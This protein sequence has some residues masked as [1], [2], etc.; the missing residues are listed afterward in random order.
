MYRR[1]LLAMLLAALAGCTTK[2]TL[3]VTAERS[4]SAD[5]PGYRT[6]R[7]RTPPVEPIPGQPRTGR[8]L[9]DWR[10][11]NVV[12]NQL[13]AKGYR[14]DSSRQADLVVECHV[15][16]KEKHTD[17]INDFIQ[18]RESGGQEGP[19]ES[20]VFGYQEGTIIVEAY[21]ATTDRLAWRGS[22]APLINP[23]SQQDKVRQAV[24]SI[25]ERFPSR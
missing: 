25:M 5:F 9:L 2:P 18:Y 1:I 23:E 11:R 13:T 8:D 12:E 16:I 15:D 20:Y 4:A 22:A 17:S 10:I 24:M 19:Q 3:R 6:Y 21:D 14:E 7:W